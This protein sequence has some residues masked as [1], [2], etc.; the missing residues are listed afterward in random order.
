MSLASGIQVIHETAQGRVRLR[1]GG[2]KHAPDL[3]HRL[4]SLLAVSALCL[5]VEVRAATGSVILQRCADVA[6]AELV[7]LVKQSLLRALAG[8]DVQAPAAA[9]AQEADLALP[10]SVL[11]SRLGADGG[12]GLTEKDAADR[13]ARYGGNRLPEEEHRSQLGV[14]ARQFQSLPVGMLGVSSAVSLASGGVADAVATLTVVALNAVFGYVTEG[15]AEAAI[16]SLM[17]VSGTKVPV[18]REGQEVLVPGRSLVPGEIILARPGVQIGADARLI[19]DDRLMVD[20]SVLTGESEAVRKRHD[21]VVTADAP[22]GA[23]PNMLHAG[24]L[25]TEGYG[26]ALVVATGVQTAAARIALL[27]GKAERPRAPVEVELDALGERLAKLSLAACALFF[28]VGWA[29]GL[30][31]TEILKDTLALAVAAVP[32]GLPVVATTTMSLGLKRMQKR[33]IL[34]RQLGAV[35]ALG[36]MQVICVDKTGTL[37]QNRLSVEMAAPGT[38]EADSVTGA[39]L[40]PLARLAA[41]ASLAQVQAGK[42]AGA[43]ATERA[44]LDFALSH[45]QVPEVLLTEVPVVDRV[46]R[47]L[48]RP[49]TGSLHQGSSP[50]MV[51]K[52]APEHVLAMCDRVAEGAQTRPLS[53]SDR[54]QIQMLNDRLAGRPARVLGFAEGPWPDDPDAPSGLTWHGLLGMVDPLRADAPQFVRAMHRA[55]LRTVM[56]TGDQTATARAIAEELDLSNGAPLRIVDAPQLGQIPP[57]LLSAVARETHVFSRVSAEHKQAI[58]RALQRSGAVVGMTGDGVNDSPALKTADVGIAMGA[59][60]TDLAREVANVVVRDDELATLADAVAQGRTIY[61]N[62]RRALEFLIA[63]N[64]SEIAVGIVEAAHGPGELETPMELLWINLVSDVLPGLGL[65]LADPDHDVLDQPPRSPEEP[66]IPPHHFRR[67]IMDTTGITVAALTSHFIGLARYGPGPETRSMTYLSLS[68]GQLLYTLFCQRSDVRHLRPGKL[69]ENRALDSA[70]LV[71][72]GL[73]V[74]PFFVPPLRRLMG[75]A[76]IGPGAVAV[77][78][79]GAVAPA[80][81]VLLRRGVVLGLDEVEG[82]P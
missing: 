63:S 36:A 42:A 60:G 53:Q 69:L 66:I 48:R 80:A 62:I 26:K 39:D 28:G 38:A 25:V 82:Q 33:G 7:G 72:I 2:I 3:C 29:R 30:A 17:D 49:W 67:M 44:M 37:T 15:Q 6:L 18:L 55:G 51:I 16:N 56:I 58:I 75:I 32:E 27:S 31:L 8:E 45:G 57:D 14:F 79:G 22:T 81:M 21:A 50:F 73:A 19:S 46:D 61:R 20:E 9:P 23:R 12:L 4:E 76:P 1:V 64:M 34:V 40:R 35:E 43:S 5:A 70:V 11:L 54:A 78:L 59:S 77:A 52:G 10:V 47:N 41:L 71:S 74:L 65:A 68:L 24:T 13:L